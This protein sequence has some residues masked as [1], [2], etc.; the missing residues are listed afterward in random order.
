MLR[1]RIAELE[2]ENNELKEK[3]YAQQNQK[4]RCCSFFSTR[5]I[6]ILEESYKNFFF[7]KFE[8]IFSKM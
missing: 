1:K 5:F 7:K 8:K 3:L 4:V 6:S 2:Q